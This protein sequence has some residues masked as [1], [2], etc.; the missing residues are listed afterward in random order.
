MVIT[1]PAQC[2]KTQFLEDAAAALAAPAEGSAETPRLVVHL[3]LSKV[4][5]PLSDKL[6]SGSSA[7]D[8][9]QLHAELA[10]ETALRQLGVPV[11]PSALRLIAARAHA[12]VTGQ[13]PDWWLRQRLSRLDTAFR[14]LYEEADKLGRE[15]RDAGVPAALAAPVIIIDNV[16]S[17]VGSKALESCGGGSV[18]ARL[19][20]LA[21]WYQ[22]QYDGDGERGVKTVMAGSPMLH[23]RPEIMAAGRDLQPVA[24]VFQL[25]D[26]D[27]P[28][29]LTALRGAGHDS[30]TSAQLVTALGTRVG[31]LSR[32]L[33]GGLPRDAETTRLVLAEQLTDAKIQLQRTFCSISAEAAIGIC[34]DA[35]KADRVH[36]DPV[37]PTQLLNP[38]PWLP[39]TEEPYLPAFAYIDSLYALQVGGAVYLPEGNRIS[40]SSAPFRAAWEQLITDWAP[41]A[42]PHK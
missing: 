16:D 2:G 7:K 38:V 27:V 18:F 19:M 9:A 10:A 13:L 41:L 29:A 39:P 17:F 42:G 31:L 1:G 8:V 40:F 3:R 20:V 30:E 37:L 15:R 26:P 21:R 22:Q 32:H 35:A 33:T 4:T 36:A 5:C 25:G 6:P 23:T 34:R 12:F 14:L 24:R 28:S 11:M